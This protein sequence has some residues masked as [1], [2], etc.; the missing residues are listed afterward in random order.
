MRMGLCVRV[1]VRVCV[2]AGAYSMC[3]IDLSSVS[4]MVSP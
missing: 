3:K 1:Q 2:R 4:L